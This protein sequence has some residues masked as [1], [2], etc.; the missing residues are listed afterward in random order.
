MNKL[1]YL[2]I[3]DYGDDDLNKKIK[4][5]EGKNGMI[6]KGEID[7]IRN[8]LFENEDQEL[9]F[10][11][12]IIKKEGGD[13]KDVYF[14][15]KYSS[16]SEQKSFRKFY[17]SCKGVLENLILLKNSRGKKFGLFSKNIHDILHGIKPQNA[18]EFQ[19][20]FVMYSFNA[21]DIFEYTFKN[22]MDIYGAFVQ[23]VFNFFSNEKIP[24][25]NK[26]YNMS[27]KTRQKG[28][29]ILGNIVEIEI[30]QVKFIK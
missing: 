26:Y 23:S 10:K 27:I 17:D 11:E 6:E 9:Y 4:G 8:S 15:L 13:I 30:Y 12:Q 24:F 28:S 20:N 21:H 22:F 7:E 14:L 5:D 19:N 25:E 2:N 1:A 29:Q 16:I 18:L 3:V